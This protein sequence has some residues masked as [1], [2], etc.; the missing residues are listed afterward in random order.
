MSDKDDKEKTPEKKYTAFHR[1]RQE[2][3]DCFTRHEVE[4]KLKDQQ[5]VFDKKLKA[6]IEEIEESQA[7]E[8]K[9][10]KTQFDAILKKIS[11]KF[12][13]YY[14]QEELNQ[15]IT[16]LKSRYNSLDR[17]CGLLE[18]QHVKLEELVLEYLNLTDIGKLVGDTFVLNEKKKRFWNK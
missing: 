16:D 2:P 5:G 7:E 4:K 15:F 11:Q 9:K 6:T 8:I 3:I 10:L 12:Q 18:K 17:F 13:E 1:E 14:T